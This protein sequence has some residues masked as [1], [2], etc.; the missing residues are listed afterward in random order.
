M[1]QKKI[2]INHFAK[3]NLCNKKNPQ[4]SFRKKEFVQQKKSAEKKSA[5]ESAE[6]ILQK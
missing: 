3:N 4:K 6:I 2:R 1:Q 5:K